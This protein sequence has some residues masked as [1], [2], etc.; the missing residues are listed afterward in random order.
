MTGSASGR[1][2]DFAW[3]ADSSVVVW[4][5]HAVGYCVVGNGLST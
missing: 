2:G 3:V 4:V 5:T 1:V